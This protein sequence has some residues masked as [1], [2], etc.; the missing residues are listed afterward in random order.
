MNFPLGQNLKTLSPYT[1]AIIDD[2]STIRLALRQILI[3]AGFQIILEAEDGVSALA[4]I[5]AKNINADL[6]L[7][8]YEMPK[9]NGVDFLRDLRAS[10]INSKVIVVA[11]K[12]HQNLLKEFLSLGISGYVVK[13]IE[14]KV[15]VE[16]IAKILDRSDYITKVI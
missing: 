4:E 12:S 8:D 10:N 7:L 14:R 2:S 5:K 16:R 3:S 11:A 15:L 6:I 1:V 13:P 9:M